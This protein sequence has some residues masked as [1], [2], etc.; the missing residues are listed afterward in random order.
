MD[1][2]KLLPFFL[3]ILFSLK[4]F[5]ATF[6]VTSNADSGPGTLRDALTQAAANGTSEKDYI[7]FN[8]ADTSKTGRRINLITEL[9]DLTSNLVIDGST[10]PGAVIGQ[11]GAHIQ[12][13][14][15]VTFD[16]FTLFQGSGLNDV[17]FYSLYMHDYTNV[18]VSDPDQKSRIGV[19]I[20]NSS[21]IIFGSPGKGNLFLGFNTYTISLNNV[22]QVTFQSNVI[23]LGSSNTLSDPENLYLG[24]AG[25]HLYECN[26]M[27]IGGDTADE[28]NTI[29]TAFDVELAQKTTGNNITIKWNNFGVFQDGKTFSFEFQDATYL[30]LST[31]GITDYADSALANCAVVNADI[32]NNLAGVIGSGFIISTMNGEVD[33]YNN[34]FGISRDGTV[35]LD[36]DSNADEGDP[37]ILSNCRATINIGSNDPTKGNFLAYSTSTTSASNCPNVLVRHNEYECIG[38]SDGG[39]ITI[40]GNDNLKGTLP[41]V[42]I[43]GVSENNGQSVL[44][45]TA[46]PGALVDIFGSES[47]TYSHC[48]IRKLIETVTANADGTWKSNLI[49]FSGFFYV[50]ATLGNITSLFETFQINSNNVT[51][52]NLRCN[53]Q[54]SITG[55]SVPQGLAHYWTDQ[56]GNIVSTNIDLNTSTAG[57][58]QFNLGGGCITKTFNIVDNRAIIDDY[59][60]AITDISC[61]NGNG[62][63]NGLFVY[64][65]ENKIKTTEWLDA[66]G[67]IVGNTTNINGL[68]AGMYY[69][70]VFTADSC[71][72]DYGPVTLKNITGPNIDQSHALIKPTNCGQ[73]V[74][75]ITNLAITGSG[76]LSYAWL[77]SQQQTVGTDS[78]LLNEPAGTYTLKVTDA[79]QCGPV[80]SSAI[81]IPQTNGIT[82]DTSGVKITIASCGSNN[83]SITGIQAIGATQ[84]QWTDANNKVVATTPGLQ[85]AAA[86]FYTFTASNTYG[87]IA[88]SRP[89]QIGLQ[90][91]VVFPGYPSKLSPSCTGESTGGI[92]VTVDTLVKSRRWV[93][94]SGQTV[95]TGNALL[96]VPAG[97]YQLYLT[98]KNGCET[99][100]NS[101]N[102]PAI[103]RLTITEGSE[104]ITSDHC[105]LMEGSVTNITITGGIPP[106][107]YAWT[108][109]NNKTLAPSLNLSGVGAGAY[110]LTVSDASVCGTVSATYTVQNQNSAILP[111]SVN[112]LQLCA[113]GNVLLKVN[114]PA[115]QYGYRLYASETSP[116]PLDEKTSGIF[117]LTVK[118]NTTYYVSQFSGECESSRTA[119]LAVVGLT[120]SD[121]VSAFTPNGDGINDTWVIN[122]ISSYADATV[123]VFTRYGQLVFESKGYPSPFDGTSNGKRLPAGVY[124]YIIKLNTNCN[125]L[126][127]SLTIIW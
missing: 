103:P 7:I 33:F 112:N 61:G 5:A 15:P 74:G 75:A 90:T 93:N 78:V 83:G 26:N 72:V 105:S 38:F 111:P 95:A 123:Q 48:S 126:T 54:A 18:D 84:Y 8:I 32:E 3:L 45:G 80:Y 69:F 85:N 98:D 86:G 12:L 116:A 96:N 60:L 51:I 109:T 57:Q 64:D 9:P 16:E 70:K 24:A 44:T 122:G 124:Y 6:V 35:N 115:A 14:T 107:S 28:G 94:G 89:Y 17:E 42:S 21:D 50:S 1:Y 120:S 53:N 76:T 71:E 110:T 63:I 118:T 39:L 55:I 104:Q 92:S 46:T 62:S 66:G 27:L 88:A 100:Y 29:F 10:Q 125:L 67:K 127:G 79:S 97:T 49:N 47:C 23:G 31:I 30:T 56:N 25:I 106:Y 81:T 108:D 40:Y 20:T 37:I 13:F 117:E 102:V 52:L 59:S 91:P 114:N 119:V 4:A 82:L 121:I 87:C 22:N 19:N 73:S 68:A 99:L 36:Q 11:S 77:N 58:Y 101:Y 41:T 65:P 34:F 2:K 43:D 113:P